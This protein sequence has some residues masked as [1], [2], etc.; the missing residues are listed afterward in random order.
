VKKLL[1]IPLVLIL[2]TRLLAQSN[3]PIRLALLAETDESS[4][5]ADVLTARLSGNPKIQLLER[6]EIEKVYREQKLSAANRDY[7]KLGQVLGADGLLLLDV[8]RTPQATNLMTRLIAVKPGVVLTEVGFSWPLKDLSSWADS[9]ATYLDSFLPKLTV[10]VKD[11]IP[12]S[13]VNLRSAVQSAEAKETER[14]LKLL[15]VQRLS[16]ERQFFV[17]ERQRMQL[18]GEEKELKADESAFWNGSYL[19]EGVVDQNGYAKD[20]IT[21]NARLTPKGGAPLLMEVSGRRTDYAEVINRLAAKVAELLKVHSTVE[22]WNATAEAQQY[23]DEAQWAMKWGV[24]A[25]AQAAA[26][27]AW[28]LGKHDQDCAMVRIKSYESTL[29]TIPIDLEGGI[30]AAIVNDKSQQIF[31]AR[32]I[33]ETLAAH[34]AVIFETNRGGISYLCLAQLPDPRDI[35]R[36]FHALELYYAFSRTLPEAAPM[37][38]RDPRTTRWHNSDW[39]NLGLEDLAAASKV[40]LSFQL[41]PESQKPVADKL[42]E[43]RAMARSVA[44]WISQSPSVRDSYFVGERLATHD[45]LDETIYSKP[46]IFSCKLKWGSLWQETPADCITLY[47]ELMASPVFGYIH[48]PLWSH[49]LQL[50]AEAMDPDHRLE[51]PRLIAWNEKDRQLIPVIWNNFIRELDGSTNVLW[52]LEAKAL[53]FADATDERQMGLTFTN[54]FEALLANRDLFLAHNVELLYLNWGADNLMEVRRGLDLSLPTPD[55]LVRQF[56]SQ[57]R[58]KL[59][60]LDQEYWDKTVPR[61]QVREAFGKQVEYLKNNTPYDWAKFNQIFELREYTKAQATEILP[62]LAAYQSNLIALAEGKSLPDRFKATNDS[63]WVELV[64]DRRAKEIL[65]A[66]APVSKTEA[67]QNLNSRPVAV[68]PPPVVARP[69]GVLSETVT[70]VLRVEKYLKLPQEQLPKEE[71]IL[72]G[73]DRWDFKIAASRWCAG[74]LVLDLRYSTMLY[75]NGV[76]AGTTRALA[77]IFNP[78]DQSWELVRYPSSDD[79]PDHLPWELERVPAEIFQGRFY[80]RD[81][82]KIKQYDFPTRQWKTLDVRV[83]PNTG[84]DAL[85]GHLYAVNRESIFEITDGGKGTRIL[86]STRRRPAASALDSLDSLGS[87]VLFS[88][89]N[90]SLG[91]VIGSKVFVWNGSDWTGLFS[92]DFPRSSPQAEALDDAVIFRF[93]SPDYSAM[94][95]FWDKS[96]PAPELSLYEKSK[97][98]PYVTLGSKPAPP[99]A[100]AVWTSPGGD[101]LVSAPGTFWKSNLYFF[102]EHAK[103][104]EV[105]PHLTAEEKSGEKPLGSME[106]GRRQ[107][108]ITDKDGYHAKLVCLSRDCAEP[109]VVPLKFDL[110]HGQPPLYSLGARMAPPGSDAGPTW[111]FFTSDTLYVGQ[112]EA[113][114]IWAIP[115]SEVEAAVAAQRQV[116]LG[117]KARATRDAEQRRKDMLAKYDHNHNGSIDPDE[118]E[119]ALDDPAYIES[120]MDAIDA[121]HNGRLEATELAWFDANQNQILDPKEQAGIDLA[122]HWLA[123]RRL[124]EFDAND[125]GFLDRSE[126]NNLWLAEP[127]LAD[128]IFRTAPAPFLDNNHDGQLDLGEL[129]TFLNQQTSRTLL[130][131]GLSRAILYEQMGIS[132]REQVDPRQMFKAT[133]E[134]YWQHPGGITNGPPFHRG[135]P[136]GRR[137]GTNGMPS[138][139]VP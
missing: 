57:Y 62:L 97:P 20:T 78:K 11:A 7:L 136:P 125:D 37:V 48:N 93:K 113:L 1:W 16:Q 52:Q 80:F 50:P 101:S 100:K 109:I 94:L 107:W 27:S 6:N 81:E 64:A 90:H 23:F 112:P 63:R 89:P 67:V 82:D 87:P 26:D 108:T 84:L 3:A 102:V 59:E 116:M 54:F 58:P 126:F 71:E 99:P 55:S 79:S 114:G 28:A 119:A 39:Y 128:P 33:K 75:R 60:A 44:G 103:V 5:A 117:N 2:A 132:P 133:V 56:Y 104:I 70:N 45:E 9:A 30:D 40:L 91:V 130:V 8:I 131:P 106:R 51:P 36:A 10:L 43:L 105:D 34:V 98:P 76:G 32:E 31:L 124:K 92:L 22:E 13:V 46:N 123:A 137:D 115:V 53:Q 110:E 74:K 19:L 134:F 41:V 42:A 73:E 83:Q 85:D 35:D 68:V 18:L 49:R 29:H 139:K 77:A 118:K 14:Q 120:E 69:S 21:I 129:A 121:N 25:E 72:E 66:P 4:T 122:Q 111:I 95:W 65:N 135:I 38:S 12:I 47:R 61:I 15:T 24:Y 96:K 17:L 127:E 88:R 86:A 138:G